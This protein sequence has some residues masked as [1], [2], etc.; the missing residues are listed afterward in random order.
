MTDVIV[1]L[2]LAALSAVGYAGAAV[3]QQRVAARTGGGG[4]RRLLAERGWWLAIALSGAGAALHVFALRYGPLTLV[5]PL[6]ALTLVAAVPLAAFTTNRTVSLREW[7]GAGITV[8]GLA[9]IFALT[10]PVGDASR[11]LDVSGVLALCA[12]TGLAVLLLVSAARTAGGV[13]GSL[14][15]AT[16]AGAAYAV[17]SVLTKTIT[18]AFTDADAVDLLGVAVAGVVA[19][20]TAG[21]LL[22]QAAYKDSDVAAPTAAVTLVNPVVSAAVGLTVLGERLAAG[23]LGAA[24]ALVFAAVAARGVVTLITTEPEADP[25][26]V[27]AGTRVDDLD[28]ALMTLNEDPVVV[29]R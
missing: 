20:A 8:L 21:M 7:R 15:Y 1:A 25:D 16:A 27:P 9:G 26:V 22:S 2:V 12:V 13:A 5:Q 10:S 24:L 18:G 14:L 11:E 4:L 23:T 28:L 19:M 6:G 17:S 3:A 29:G